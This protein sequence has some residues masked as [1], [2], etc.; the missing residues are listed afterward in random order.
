MAADVFPP[1]RS[2]HELLLQIPHTVLQCF[3][4]FAF[5]SLRKAFDTFDEEISKRK[6]KEG[7]K[8][9]DRTLGKWKNSG[10][11]ALQCVSA[12]GE[13]VVWSRSSSAPST[14]PCSAR[15]EL[16]SASIVQRSSLK[17]LPGRG[18]FTGLLHQ[19]RISTSRING[20]ITHPVQ[21]VGSCVLIMFFFS[22]K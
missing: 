16:W 21:P 12:D 18:S 4:P 11:S 5:F 22:A 6:K 17:P 13:R 1:H 3:Q 7:K 20:S 8:E 10:K 15:L 2:L 19:S 9:R 14:V